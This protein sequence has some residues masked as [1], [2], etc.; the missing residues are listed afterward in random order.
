MSY[1]VRYPG[2]I[3]G[4]RPKL[5]GAR[6]PQDRRGY[7]TTGG[8]P[9]TQFVET[10]AGLERTFRIAQAPRPP[11][12]SGR[13]IG[14]RENRPTSSTLVGVG[15]ISAAGA[16]GGMLLAMSQHRLR[17]RPRPEPQLIGFAAQFERRLTCRAAPV[18]RVHLRTA[19]MAR[20]SEVRDAGGATGEGPELAGRWSPDHHPVEGPC[21]DPLSKDLQTHAGQEGAGGVPDDP[22]PHADLG[23]APAQRFEKAAASSALVGSRLQI[24]TIRTQNGQNTKLSGVGGDPILL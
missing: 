15:N 8:D 17:R 4:D 23:R 22:R 16:D 5:I 19:L 21:H 12:N 6:S 7:Y 2:H 24:T 13:L 14:R 11:G 1:Q 20:A 18:G 9:V 10:D 3:A